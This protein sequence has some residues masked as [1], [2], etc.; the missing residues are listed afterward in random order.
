MFCGSTGSL[1]RRYLGP[2]TVTFDARTPQFSV[3]GF[4]PFDTTAYTFQGLYEENQRSAGRG[5]QGRADIEYD[6][7]D[8]FPKNIQ[9]GGRCTDRGAT[10][11]FGS[12][13]AYLLPLGINASTLPVQYNVFA[14]G[15]AGTDAQGLRGWIAPTYEGIRNNLTALRQFVIN[16]CPAVVAQGDL[17]NGCRNYTLTPVNAA[18]Q[19]N[20]YEE[21][22][23]GYLQANYAFGD[24]V[25]GMVGV[26]VERTRERVQGQQPEQVADFN[27]TNEFTDHLPNVSA[28]VHLGQ[29][30]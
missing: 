17:G 2:H 18:L 4:N 8:G 12:R 7:D 11:E 6:F 13:Y 21:T 24:L 15:F 22:L 9:A 27:A 20:A 26:R 25:D 30:A 28:R 23:A 16:A 1:D 14:T 3:G 5:W 19:Y 10:R 29:K